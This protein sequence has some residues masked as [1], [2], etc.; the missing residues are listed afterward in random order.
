MLD[1]KWQI[2]PQ[3]V[4]VIVKGVVYVEYEKIILTFKCVA[5]IKE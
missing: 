2:T 5:K 3:G 1:G 4:I